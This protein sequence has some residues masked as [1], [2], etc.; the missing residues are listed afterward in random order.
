MSTAVASSFAPYRASDRAFFLAMAAVAWIAILAGFGPGLAA[1][2][3]GGS[4]FPAAIV[5]SPT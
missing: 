3:T 5:R 4:A 2:A 1:H